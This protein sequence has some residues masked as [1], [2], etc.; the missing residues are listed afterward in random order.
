MIPLDEGGG[1]GPR[2][3]LQGETDAD[4]EFPALG[5]RACT[6]G[7]ATLDVDYGN[8]PTSESSW[9]LRM[10]QSSPGFAFLS[11]QLR[12]TMISKVILGE[13]M[14]P[15]VRT[16]TTTVLALIYRVP[17]A[18]RAR[19]ATLPEGEA[20]KEGFGPLKVVLGAIPALYANREVPS[21]PLAPSSPLLN[22]FP[23]NR[24]CKQQD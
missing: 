24:R 11:H 5:L 8:R 7:F 21:V 10:L 4:P 14:H 22:A 12:A 9:Y 15:E 13:Q 2:I 6:P 1:I 20:A 23:G 18:K 17:V 3:M 16:N 19:R